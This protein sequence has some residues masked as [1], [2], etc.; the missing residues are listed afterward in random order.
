[1]PAVNHAL[2]T[3]AS[4]RMTVVAIM[5]GGTRVTGRSRLGTK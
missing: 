2:N 1:M 3:L 5:A 4:V